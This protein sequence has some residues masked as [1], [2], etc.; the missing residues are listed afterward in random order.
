MGPGERSPELLGLSG[1]D[2]VRARDSRSDID[3]E[4][5]LGLRPELPGVA[6]RGMKSEGAEEGR[7]GGAIWGT[8]G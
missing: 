2:G 3:I 5:T 1:A 4:L 7:F 8:G 6:E